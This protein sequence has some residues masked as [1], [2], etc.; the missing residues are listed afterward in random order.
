MAYEIKIT[1]DA[2]EDLDEIV[3]YITNVLKNPIAANN[4]LTEIEENYSV[5]SSAPESFAYCNDQ[6][7]RMLGYRKIPVKNYIVF[8]KTDNDA[9]IVYIMRIIYGRREYT[10][11]I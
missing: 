4:F 5:L 10:K 11:L 6:R 2:A 8:Y 3:G 9:K 7:L 1:E